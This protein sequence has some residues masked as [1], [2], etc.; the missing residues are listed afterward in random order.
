MQGRIEILE[1]KPRWLPR[2]ALRREYEQQSKRVA[3]RGDRVG[4]GAE[5][6]QQ[7]VCEEALDE[8]RE[9]RRAHRCS[10]LAAASSRSAARRR[11]SGTAWMYQ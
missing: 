11:S 9:I 3:V 5:L 8:R 6:C 2:Q 7:P 4:A 1:T 10:P